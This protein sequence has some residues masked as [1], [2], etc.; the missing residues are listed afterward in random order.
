MTAENTNPSTYLGGTWVAWGAG[1]V[2]VGVDETNKNFETAEKTGGSETSGL[3]Y[4][5]HDAVMA[6]SGAFGVDAYD[7][8]D[9]SSLIPKAQGDQGGGYVITISRSDN[10][11]DMN[12]VLKTGSAGRSSASNLQ[13]YITC[14]MWKRTA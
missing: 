8:G 3:P 2:P 9:S 1:R 12:K 11:R 14:Y 6:Y 5:T 13:P 10:R 7:G 4:H